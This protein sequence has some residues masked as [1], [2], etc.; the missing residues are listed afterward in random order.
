LKGRL[1]ALGPLPRR[2]PTTS[3]NVAIVKVAV[4]GG[5]KRVMGKIEIKI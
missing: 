4:V 1:T 2:S 5:G 3:Y